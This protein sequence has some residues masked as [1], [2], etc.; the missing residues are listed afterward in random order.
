MVWSFFLVINVS[1]KLYGLYSRK[2]L[3]SLTFFPSSFYLKRPISHTNVATTY[4]FSVAFHF[5]YESD[6]SVLATTF[7]LFSTTFF[8]D[9]QTSK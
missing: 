6:T 3:G 7:T 1:N 5:A 8:N 9:D 4:L 2:R